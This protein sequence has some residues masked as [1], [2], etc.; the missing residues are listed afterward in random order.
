M[1]MYTSRDIH[2]LKRV[3]QNPKLVLRHAYNV[4]PSREALIQAAA[5]CQGVDRRGDN[6]HRRHVRCCWS[7]FQNMFLAN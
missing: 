3:R 4:V 5:S 1:R 7:F 6:R 2:I